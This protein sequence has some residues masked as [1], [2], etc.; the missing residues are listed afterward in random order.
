MVKT[1][2]WLCSK[3]HF[4]KEQARPWKKPERWPVPMAGVNTSPLMQFSD[5]SPTSSLEMLQ[6]LWEA[7]PSVTATKHSVVYRQKGIGDTDLLL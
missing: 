7:I 2:P 4:L 5:S 1:S 6:Q 3:R